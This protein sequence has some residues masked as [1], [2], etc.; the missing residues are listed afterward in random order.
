M[1]AR[2]FIHPRSNER[3]CEALVRFQA[4]G[5]A[6]SNTRNGYIEAKPFRTVTTKKGRVVSLAKRFRKTIFLSDKG[7]Q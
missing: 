5:Y 4:I 2:I 7:K 1:S 3:L 6:F